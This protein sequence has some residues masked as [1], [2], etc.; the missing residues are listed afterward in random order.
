MRKNLYLLKNHTILVLNEGNTVNMVSTYR[1]DFTIN[2]GSGSRIEF[3]VL[4][5]NRKPVLLRGKKI[6]IQLINDLTNELYLEKDMNIINHDD[7]RTSLSLTPEEIDGMETGYYRY[8]IEIIDLDTGE[9]TFLNNDNVFNVVGYIKIL[10]NS[11]PRFPNVQKSTNFFPVQMFID[12]TLKITY[13]SGIFKSNGTSLTTIAVTMNNF[14]GSISVQGSV[15][16]TPPT[17]DS[18]WS[19]VLLNLN[20]FQKYNNFT[21]TDSFNI[22]G[23][24]NFFRFIYIPEINNSG[25]IE[26]VLFL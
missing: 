11:L 24:Y 19:T 14:S 5:I 22:V 13:H 20:Q 4:D 15:S 25:K 2:K 21:G 23:N 6:K 12:N 1:N 8:L 17:D 10:E 9:R 26:K 3:T 7:G 16:P 18:E